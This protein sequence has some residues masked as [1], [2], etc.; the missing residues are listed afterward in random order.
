MSQVGYGE[1][2]ENHSVSRNVRETA[3]IAKMLSLRA[4]GLSYWNIADRLN[5]TGVSTKT[6]KGGWSSKTVYQIVMRSKMRGAS[7]GKSQVYISERL[8]KE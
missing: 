3:V 6:G 5:A 4:E 7:Q 2:W 1:M 8:L